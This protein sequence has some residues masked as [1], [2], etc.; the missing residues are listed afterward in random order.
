MADLTSMPA[1]C[2]AYR[3]DGAVRLLTV[4][5]PKIGQVRAQSTTPSAAQC[6]SR[7]DLCQG[8]RRRDFAELSLRM[9]EEQPEGV[10]VACQ[11]MATDL[12]LPIDE[13]RFQQGEECAGRLHGSTRVGLFE[14][15]YG[16][17]Q[18]LRRGGQIPIGV[19]D[20]RMAKIGR[21]RRQM[22][23]DIDTLASS[24]LTAMRWRRSCC[25]GPWGSFGPRG[26]IP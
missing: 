4:Q 14:P 9:L 26:P 10:A 21:E 13:E 15:Q 19:V 12:P 20:V 7:R 1:H 2:A 23:F 25:R 24:V 3:R 8:Q 5:S 6:P 17:L 22:P 16:A 11:G 18:Q